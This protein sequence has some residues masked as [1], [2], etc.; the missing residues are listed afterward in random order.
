MSLFALFTLTHC[1]SQFALNCILYANISQ[2]NLVMCLGPALYPSL[3][4]RCTFRFI[5]SRVDIIS[6]LGLG[7]I[8]L[9]ELSKAF[10]YL[11][12]RLAR[13]H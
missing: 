1:F 5:A 7:G 12:Q 6:L 10:V 9:C 11:L 8:S 3:R 4:G 13:F 2:Y